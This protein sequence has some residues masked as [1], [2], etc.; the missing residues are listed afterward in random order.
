M[1]VR[2]NPK[3]PFSL[4]ATSKTVFFF[5]FRQ[6]LPL[7]RGTVLVFLPGKYASMPNLKSYHPLNFGL[8][9]ITL[10]TRL[11]FVFINYVLST[12]PVPLA[13]Q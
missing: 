5:L 8:F 11:N 4:A 10:E 2:D 9:N 3:A 6:G 12:K 1:L 7:E 13:K